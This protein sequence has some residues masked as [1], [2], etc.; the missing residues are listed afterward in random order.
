MPI[1]WANYNTALEPSMGD[2]RLL[3]FLLSKG[4]N[5]TGL[6]VIHNNQDFLQ[7]K[8]KVDLIITNPPFS[9]ARQFAEHAIT[10]C[11]TLILLQRLNWLGSKIRHD[12]WQEHKL[13]SIFVLSRRP[14]FDREGTDMT[15]YAW[16]VWQNDEKFIESGI[17]HIK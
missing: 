6:D 11:N 16:F 1:N 14:S 13:D 4:L 2:G 7:W 3:N 8:G 9:K 5:A 17:H 10:K 12:F 15:E